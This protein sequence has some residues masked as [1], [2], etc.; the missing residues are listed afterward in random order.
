LPGPWLAIEDQMRV[1]IHAELPLID[2]QRAH[3]VLLSSENLGK[4]VLLP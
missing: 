4:V 1:A 3:R 2:A